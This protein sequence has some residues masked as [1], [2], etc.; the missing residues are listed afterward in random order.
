MVVATLLRVKTY[1]ME[2]TP[3][4]SEGGLKMGSVRLQKSDPIRSI[5]IGGAPFVIGVIV[6]TLALGYIAVTFKI[7]DIFSSWGMFGLTIL[8]LY[9]LFAITNTMFSSKKDMDGIWIIAVVIAVVLLILYF[10]QINLSYYVELF[11]TQK[12]FI[13]QAWFMVKLLCIPLILNS[14]VLSISKLITR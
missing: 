13:N 6:L 4:Y 9:L 8:F 14:I 5:L 2:F 11:L 1:G 3:E 10:A 7:E 12:V